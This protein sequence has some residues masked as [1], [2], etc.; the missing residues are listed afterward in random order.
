[1]TTGASEQAWRVTTRQRALDA[2][3]CRP[4]RSVLLGLRVASLRSD[5]TE[6]DF[7]RARLTSAD[8][9]PCVLASMTPVVWRPLPSG[10]DR[11][12]LDPSEIA[13]SRYVFH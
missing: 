1:M 11:G 9:L 13:F 3:P 2:V 4:Q 7:V 5:K 6:V 10:A 12:N 8:R